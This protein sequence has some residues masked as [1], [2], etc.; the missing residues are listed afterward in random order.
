LHHRYGESQGNYYDV[1]SETGY[2]P[3]TQYSVQQLQQLQPSQ[4]L[5]N[6]T[7]PTRVLS[8]PTM[9]Q[10]TPPF[11]PISHKQRN[12]TKSN[13]PAPAPTPSPPAKQILFS[14]EQLV[15]LNIR[16]KTTPTPSIS[17]AVNKY[18]QRPLAALAYQNEMP[19]SG[20]DSR[21]KQ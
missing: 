8:D 3:H 20:D 7:A 21:W 12:A 19:S 17:S 16:E 5:P 15:A 11:F 6:E 14:H 1:V 13:Q 9:E 2:Y 4:S 10:S 18:L